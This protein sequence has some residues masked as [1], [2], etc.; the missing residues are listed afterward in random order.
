MSR[1]QI[2][3]TLPVWIAVACVLFWLAP[4]PPAKPPPTEQEVAATERATEFVVRDVRRWQAEHGDLSRPWD[5][6]TGHLAIV[7]DDV[8]REL[9]VLEK[10]TALRF[11]LTFAVLPG[12]VYASGVQLRLTQD[13]RRYRELLLHLP[14]EPF[15]SSQMTAG[16]EVHENFLLTSDER[17]VLVD[18]LTAALDSVP[19]ALGVNNHMGSRLTADEAAMD[20]VMAELARRKL[21][22]LD[23]R[24]NPQTVAESTARKHGV[25]TGAR[26][27]FLDNELDV[28]AIVA[29]LDRAAAQSLDGPVVAIGHPSVELHEA[30]NRR[31]PQLHADGIAVYPLSELLARTAQPTSVQSE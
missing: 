15:D 29:Q 21:L 25:L 3:W 8:G 2:A 13:R 22:F 14:M 23:S 6:A 24:T 17:S 31:L 12:S 28:E 27:V 30:L 4:D 9:H 26:Q 19:M 20:A 10:L 11:R 18:K 5:E 7:I 1:A 16:P